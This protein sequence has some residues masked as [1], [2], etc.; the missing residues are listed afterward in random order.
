MFTLANFSDC[1]F[2]GDIKWLE[3]LLC[4]FGIAHWGYHGRNAKWM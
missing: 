3:H 4:A 2:R 1:N